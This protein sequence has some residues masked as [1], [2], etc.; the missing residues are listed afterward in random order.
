MLQRVLYVLFFIGKRHDPDNRSLPGVMMFELRDGHVKF[1]AEAIFQAAQHLP[2]VLK[3]LRMLDVKL[4]GKQTDRH[5]RLRDESRSYLRE[6]AAVLLLPW[7]AASAADTLVISKH[8][9]TSP[10]FTSLKLAM[11]APHSNPERTSLASSLKRFKEL[12]L[13][14]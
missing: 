9:R 1:C 10:T 3:R 4:E 8:S 12:S 6:D 2:F 11:P 14:V 13:E 5:E 7:A